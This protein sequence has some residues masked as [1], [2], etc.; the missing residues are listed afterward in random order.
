MLSLLRAFKQVVMLV[1]PFQIWIVDSSSSSLFFF[2]L[3]IVY[4]QRTYCLVFYLCHFEEKD[5]F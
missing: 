1:W 4:T 5:S 2:H 3:I